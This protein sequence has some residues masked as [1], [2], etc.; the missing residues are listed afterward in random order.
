MFLD[1]IKDQIDE[2]RISPI[3]RV[4]FREDF[5]LRA[6]QAHYFNGDRFII[7][8]VTQTVAPTALTC[9]NYLAWLVVERQVMKR[10][11]VKSLDDHFLGLNSYKHT[12]LFAEV[13]S[14]LQL[15]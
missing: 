11:T 10:S 5:K 2:V 7:R 8:N 14:F 15:L 1:T 12:A 4:D 13:E 6:S 3:V 9:Y